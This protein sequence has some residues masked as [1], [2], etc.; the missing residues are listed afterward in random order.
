MIFI[1]WLP[2]AGYMAS[3]LCHLDPDLSW[4][5]FRVRN[6]QKLQA[7]RSMLQVKTVK[8]AA[9]GEWRYR[10]TSVRRNPSLIH[11]Q[12]PATQSCNIKIIP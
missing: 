4:T 5:H 3:S 6:Y 2:A 9:N 10:S 12:Q 1:F 11:A 8:R 7:A